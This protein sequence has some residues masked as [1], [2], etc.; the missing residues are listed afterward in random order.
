M[1]NNKKKRAHLCVDGMQNNKKRRAHLCVHGYVLELLR[2][3]R[4]QGKPYFPSYTACQGRTWY[5]HSEDRP[6]FPGKSQSYRN[7][8]KRALKDHP[9]ARLRMVRS[10]SA[11]RTAMSLARSH[12]FTMSQIRTFSR[13]TTETEATKYI[14]AGSITPIASFLGGVLPTCRKQET[15]VSCAGQRSREDRN[16]LV[17]CV[18]AVTNLA[19]ILLLIVDRVQMWHSSPA[20]G[21][22]SGP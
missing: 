5:L 17:M 19:M 22:V 6:I 3:A 21:A 15:T 10:H 14:D 11:K 8:L 20:S 1:Q 16:C 13:H 18:L 7:A 2:E 9:D 12:G 4:F